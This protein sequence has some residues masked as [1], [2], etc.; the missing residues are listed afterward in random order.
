MI[1]K[2]EPL[3]CKGKL[4]LFPE[5]SCLYQLNVFKG[6]NLSCWLRSKCLRIPNSVCF[7]GFAL[8]V[9]ACSFNL[10]ACF[11]TGSFYVVQACL[12]SKGAGITGVCHH[13]QQHWSHHSASLHHLC[14]P[15]ICV[16]LL[17]IRKGTTQYGD[18]MLSPLGCST[19]KGSEAAWETKAGWLLPPLPHLTPTE[20][21]EELSV[22]FPYLTN[23]SYSRRTQA[24][25]FN[26]LTGVSPNR[27]THKHG[28]SA[29]CA[30]SGKP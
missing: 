17:E 2:C 27:R 19:E 22:K 7:L 24:I 15:F 18:R 16:G 13:G 20:A 23:G 6:E 26:I 10:L 11:D 8:C 9:L 28:S 25:A 1:C 30:H 3:L 5:A 4:L 14:S 12:W 21:W 29:Y